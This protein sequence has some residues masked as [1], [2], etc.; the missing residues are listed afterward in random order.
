MHDGITLET[1]GRPTAV[2]VTTEFVHEAEVQR[3]ALG[4]TDLVPVIID[5]PVSTLSETELDARAE[6]AVTQAVGKF[7]GTA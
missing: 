4:M 7:L 5:H 2:I 6:S 1:A 3:A